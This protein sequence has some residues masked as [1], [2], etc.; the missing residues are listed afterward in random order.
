MRKTLIV[1]LN[2][3]EGSVIIGRDADKITSAIWKSWNILY[4]VR[5]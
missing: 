3:C 5:K 1:I 4:A 2:E